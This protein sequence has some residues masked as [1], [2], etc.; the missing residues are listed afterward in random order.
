MS[1]PGDVSVVVSG[2]S[3]ALRRQ[4]RPLEWVVLEEVALDAVVEDGRLVARTSARQIAE[5]LGIDPGTAVTALRALRDR[6][7]LRLCREKGPGG[8]FGLSVYQLGPITGLSVIGPH[9]AEPHMAEPHVLQSTV[10]RPSLAEPGGEAP[11][12]GP[13]WCGGIAQGGGSVSCPDRSKAVPA[14]P[15]PSL[16]CPGQEAFDFGSA[17]S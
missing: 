12:V 9:M 1:S 11:H 2:A 10:V 4:L 17:S 15:V 7:L 6:G 5:R 16:Q 8:R 14:L 13:P 3:R